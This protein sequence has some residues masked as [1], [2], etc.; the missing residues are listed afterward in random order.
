MT[1]VDDQTA[2]EQQSKLTCKRNLKDPSWR[3]SQR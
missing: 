3:Q 1:D 2:Q